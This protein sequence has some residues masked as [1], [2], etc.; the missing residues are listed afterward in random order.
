MENSIVAN[1]IKQNDYQQW[2]FELLELNKRLNAI[3]EE[4]GKLQKQI[5][6]DENSAEQQAASETEKNIAILQNEIFDDYR[7]LNN[8]LK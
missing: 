7:Y 6:P 3:K 2:M 4:F 5:H 8:K 1:E